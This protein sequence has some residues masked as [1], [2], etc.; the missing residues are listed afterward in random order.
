MPASTSFGF[1]NAQGTHK[2]VFEYY[3]WCRIQERQ[4]LLSPDPKLNTF[5]E[6]MFKKLNSKPVRLRHQSPEMQFKSEGYLKAEK[7][8]KIRN[9][10]NIDTKL[11]LDDGNE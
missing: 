11:Y 5:L 7:L 4:N 6:K 1:F 2:Y 10:A 3:I 9:M 8:K